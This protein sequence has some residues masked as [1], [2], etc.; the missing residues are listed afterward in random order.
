MGKM[1]IK[2]MFWYMRIGRGIYGALFAV[3]FIMTL[4]D[5][6]ERKSTSFTAI[7]LDLTLVFIGVILESC[8]IVYRNRGTIYVEADTRKDRLNLAQYHTNNEDYFVEESLD[9]YVVKLPDKAYFKSYNKNEVNVVEDPKIAVP[10]VEIITSEKISKPADNEYSIFALAGDK[11]K[12]ENQRII[13]KNRAKD[14]KKTRD[15][16]V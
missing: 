1:K 16:V 4:T 10:V 12:N 8:L 5:I 7:A 6:A 13:V 2:L 15:S 9:E 11:I 14:I 3:A